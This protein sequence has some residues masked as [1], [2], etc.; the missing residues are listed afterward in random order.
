[1]RDVRGAGAIFG[2]DLT[3]PSGPFV[4]AILAKGVI[5]N[6]TSDTVIR[7]LPPLIYKREHITEVV[8]TIRQTFQEWRLMEA[9]G[10]MVVDRGA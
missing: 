10:G 1:M 7:L 9:V 5:V 3:V 6:A 2:L 8:A 4:D